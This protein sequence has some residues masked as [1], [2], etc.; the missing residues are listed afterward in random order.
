[1]RESASYFA[2]GRGSHFDQFRNFEREQLAVWGWGGG[3][4]EMDGVIVVRRRS[5][6]EMNNRSVRHAGRFSPSVHVYTRHWSSPS[7]RFP[8]G[9]SVSDADPVSSGNVMADTHTHVA[10]SPFSCRVHR[11]SAGISLPVVGCAFEG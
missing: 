6:A 3:Q 5:F 4:F 10:T 2:A 9:V 11:M 7:Y 8:A 1:M